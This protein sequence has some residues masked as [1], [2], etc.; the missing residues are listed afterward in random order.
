MRRIGSRTDRGYIPDSNTLTF[1][2][3]LC[4]GMS[5]EDFSAEHVKYDVSN[6]VAELRLANPDRRNCFSL[7]MAEA[8]HYRLETAILDGD[9][10]AILVTAEGPVFSAGVE[11]DLLTG[12]DREA[13]EAFV[14]LETEFFYWMRNTTTPIVA[15]ATGPVVGVA[16][17]LFLYGAHMTVAAPDVEIWWP[18]VEHGIAPV[19][20]AVWLTMAAGR[21]HTLETL[22]LGERFTAERARELGLVNRTVDP[23]EAAAT[24]RELAERVATLDREHGIA[25]DFLKATKH[26]ER[27]M[28]ADST[29]WADW[30]QHGL[31]HNR[32]GS[33]RG[34]QG[35]VESGGGDNT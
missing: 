27:D 15:A 18:E 13:Y 4:R 3:L 17:T 31:E 29:A 7:A 10:H 14:D 26:A 21:A 1:P 11:L 5:A 8:F 32:K 22:M 23:D 2:C 35:S 25:A 6:G 33:E 30:R 24:A 34:R 19:E 16:A 28:I 20:R 12:D 9:V